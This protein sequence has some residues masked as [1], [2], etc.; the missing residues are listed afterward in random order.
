[1]PPNGADAPQVAA[2]RVSGDQ[3]LGDQAAAPQV[4]GAA[5]NRNS[6]MRRYGQRSGQPLQRAVIVLE[7]QPTPPVQPAPAKQE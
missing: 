1:M 7:V 2:P 3:V 4:A 6:A 5:S